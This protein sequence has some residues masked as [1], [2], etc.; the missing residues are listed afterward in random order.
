MSRL[1][2]LAV[3]NLGI[4]YLFWGSTYLGI[5][6]ALQAWP[7]FLL[8][9]T[10]ML[11]AGALM[12]LAARALGQPLRLDRHAAV[13][14]IV[15]GLILFPAGNGSVTWAEQTTPSGL[16]ATLVA[17]VPIWMTLLAWL[18]G[19]H[20]RPS[21]R[22]IAAL[23]LGLAG[24]A[25]LVAEGPAA[26]SPVN[27][28]VL[29]LGAAAWAFASVWVAKRRPSG[30]L[31]VRAAYQMLAGGAGLVAM[32]L[33]A[34]ETA[35]V[36]P[37]LLSPV[38]LL[39]LGYLVVFGSCVGFVSFQWLIGHLP[40]HISGTYAFVNP[41]VAVIL[42]M[43]FGEK[44]TGQTLLAIAL[45]VA[46]VALAAIVPEPTPRPAPPPVARPLPAPGGE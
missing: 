6:F 8:G 29:L 21:L 35:R 26:V 43:L 39:S 5:R 44:V 14:S 12:L 42:G 36:G 1:T 10:R 24:V 41:V 22:V 2:P 34:G 13:T 9:G 32:S 4:V 3:A 31:F 17:T 46:G 38:P 7:P 40:P 20:A 25:L 30:P 45:V 23:G 15:S 19:T 28:L 16:A 37:A 27:S 33:A 11:T 18:L